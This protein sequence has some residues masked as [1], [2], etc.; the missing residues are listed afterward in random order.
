MDSRCALAG[1]LLPP[2]YKPSQPPINSCRRLPGLWLSALGLDWAFEVPGQP[3]RI[4]Q[5]SDT[6]LSLQD[7]NHTGLLL[8]VSGQE[9]KW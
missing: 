6:A 2:T 8:V 5:L 3:L 4:R 7:G 1:G 9:E